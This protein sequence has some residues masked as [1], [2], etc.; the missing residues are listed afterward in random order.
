[1]VKKAKIGE[2]TRFFVENVCFK[3]RFGQLSGIQQFNLS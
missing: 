3:T 1:M 2:K